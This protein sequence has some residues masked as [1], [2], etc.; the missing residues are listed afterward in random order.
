VATG[1]AGVAIAI[2]RRTTAGTLVSMS[3]MTC[4]RSAQTREDAGLAGRI[5]LRTA[6]AEELPFA[7]DH[8]TRSRSRM[9]FDYVSDPATTVASSPA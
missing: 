9:S 3:A 4:S 8:S 2:A 5:E 7:D 1:T 6:R